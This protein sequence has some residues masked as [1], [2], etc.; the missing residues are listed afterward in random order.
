MRL[1]D[2]PLKTVMADMSDIIVNMEKC[3]ADGILTDYDIESV[4]NHIQNLVN[5]VYNS[6][7]VKEGVDDIM[8]GNVLYTRADELVDQG[9][10]QGIE[11]GVEKGKTQILTLNSYLIRDD[12]LEDL[13]KSTT[14]SDFLNQLL[15]EYEL[16]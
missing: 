12:R 11:Q 15:K 3:Y 6:D 5:N 2:E 10:E 4:Y 13:K 16:I 7:T 9:I 8:G 14:D 1:E